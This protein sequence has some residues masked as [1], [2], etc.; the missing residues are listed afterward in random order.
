MVNFQLLD[1]FG[2]ECLIS[3]G[4]AVNL[5]AHCG[6]AVLLIINLYLLCVVL[7]RGGED[8]S[9]VSNRF[10]AAA[11]AFTALRDIMVFILY[12]GVSGVIF[13]AFP[14]TEIDEGDG[15]MRS[16]LRV[17]LTVD[18]NSTE[19]A[20]LSAFASILLVVWVLGI[21]V[22]MSYKFWRNREGLH[23][24]TVA[25]RRYRRALEAHEEQQQMDVAASN[26][27]EREQQRRLSACSH[28]VALH[29]RSGCDRS[30]PLASKVRE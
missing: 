2:I 20:W 17:D 13:S 25:E 22:F 3:Y 6:G 21:P 4:F 9:A 11:E 7:H 29:K 23:F 1:L 16:L 5:L 18:C 19:Y 24:F 12:P 15:G 14:C 10:T 8:S 26:I 27:V 30:R 28:E